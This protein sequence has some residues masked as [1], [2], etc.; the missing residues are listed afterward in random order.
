MRLIFQCLAKEGTSRQSE[1]GWR[2]PVTLQVLEQQRRQFA[3]S[4]FDSLFPLRLII[5]GRCPARIGKAGRLFG[6]PVLMAVIHQYRI[7]QTQEVAHV[8]P[9]ATVS[10]RSVEADLSA[11]LRQ[12]SEVRLE[13]LIEHRTQKLGQGRKLF[14]LLAHHFGIHQQALSKVCQ[15]LG[16]D[17]AGNAGERH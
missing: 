13:Q 11:A 17:V 16:E 8:L 1:G 10:G 3:R 7:T 6:W 15:L 9:F 4:L 14:Q 5:G 12:R 2:F